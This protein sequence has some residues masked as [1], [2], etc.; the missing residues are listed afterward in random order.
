MS[1]SNLSSCGWEEQIMRRSVGVEER[2]LLFGT[3][4]G[5]LC[6]S[7]VFG[8][9]L[10]TPVYSFSSILGMLRQAPS[11]L[12]TPLPPPCLLIKSALCRLKQ[13]KRGKV[14]HLHSLSQEEEVP[15][16][17]HLC[18]VL[19][20][21]PVAQLEMRCVRSESSKAHMLHFLPL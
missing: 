20:L 8:E 6:N 14:G 5:N 13:D 15:W 16:C 3:N 12:N 17:L 2:W 11:L 10:A 1:F 19:L 21:Q 7:V 4:T 18:L 9:P